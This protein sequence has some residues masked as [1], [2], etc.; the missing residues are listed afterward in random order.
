M[1]SGNAKIEDYTDILVSE[2]KPQM[3]FSIMPESPFKTIVGVI[4]P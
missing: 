1:D 2:L 4:E 3:K